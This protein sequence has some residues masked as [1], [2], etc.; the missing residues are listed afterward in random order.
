MSFSCRARILKLLAIALIA[1]TG[2]PAR[3]V[4]Q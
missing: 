2:G 3:A 4:A 1:V